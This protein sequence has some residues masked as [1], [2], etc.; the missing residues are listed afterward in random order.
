MHQNIT[1]GI[2]KEG[3]HLIKDCGRD[4]LP[5]F[6]K[7]A[8]YNVGAEIGVYKGEYTKKFLDEGLRM[9]AIDPWIAY[10][11]YKGKPQYVARKK[12]HRKPTT[13]ILPKHT[14]LTRPHKNYLIKR[15][16]DPDELEFKWRLVSTGP[17]GPYKHRI[18]APIYFNEK[19]VSYQGRDITDKAKL[20]YKAC[21]RILEVGKI[22]MWSNSSS[23]TI[24]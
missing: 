9:Y 11:E 14:E 7:S 13:I 8:G 24:C 10:A 3:K 15:N 6:L 17:V 12:S 22:Y 4:D 19:L 18:I 2:K 5:K 23:P 21:K 1:E 16:F 20:K